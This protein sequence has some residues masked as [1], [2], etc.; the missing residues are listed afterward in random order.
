M[1]DLM[2]IYP[3]LIS[4]DLL[5]LGHIIAMLDDHCNGYHLDVM[6]DHFVPNL[7]WGP[8]FINRIRQVTTK[9]LDI[10]LMVDNPQ[11]WLTRL[12][13]NPNDMITFHVESM[14]D[15]SQV[16]SFTSHIQ[17]S[18]L[19]AGIALNPETPVEKVFPH[20]HSVNHI[21]LMSVNPGF[22]GQT[23][24]PKVINKISP[25]IIRREATHAKFLLG[26]D[27]GINQ[28]NLIPLAQQK[29]DYICAASAIFSQKDPVA[30]I[31]ALRA[32]YEA[33]L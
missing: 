10:H 3:S 9:Q 15:S 17:A 21:L 14:H 25:L 29:I 6:D 11:S 16:A 5:N 28:E 20:V 8:D 27:G 2:K 30:A 26:M 1:K 23:F 13:L 22:S 7:T 33:G 32:E 31:Q 12:R 4:A 18:Q 24:I 19:N